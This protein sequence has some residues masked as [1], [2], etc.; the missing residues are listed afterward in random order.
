MNKKV[1]DPFDSMLVRKLLC[2][3][4][5]SRKDFFDNIS[6]TNVMNRQSEN[7]VWYIDY[8]EINVPVY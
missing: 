5:K 2:S 1:S 3:R 4:M 8:V 6:V 7:D